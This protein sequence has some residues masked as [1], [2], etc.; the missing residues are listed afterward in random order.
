MLDLSEDCNIVV[1][2]TMAFMLSFSKCT[3]TCPVYFYGA[4]LSWI[5]YTTYINDRQPTSVS[6]LQTRRWTTTGECRRKFSLMV[7]SRYSISSMVS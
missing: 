2:A 6:L 4:T 5:T 1:I 7:A 3:D